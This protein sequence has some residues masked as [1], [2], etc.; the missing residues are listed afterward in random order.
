MVRLVDIANVMLC[1]KARQTAFLTKT[2]IN[3][4]SNTTLL[5][6]LANLLQHRV[7]QNICA[8]WHLALPFCLC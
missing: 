3:S 8:Y 4:H 2:S 7:T 1:W 6:H 5:K